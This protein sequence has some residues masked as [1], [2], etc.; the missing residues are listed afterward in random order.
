MLADGADFKVMGGDLIWF[1][2]IATVTDGI[3]AEVTRLKPEIIK[4]FL[5]GHPQSR[6]T[7]GRPEPR[8]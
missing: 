2:S 5:G 8:G 4:L 6:R 1:G 3:R 7:W